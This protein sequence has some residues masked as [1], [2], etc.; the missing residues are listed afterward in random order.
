MV[1]FIAATLFVLLPPTVLCLNAEDC[2]TQDTT[3]TAEDLVDSLLDVGSSLA[4]QKLCQEAGDQQ[5][6]H[7]TWYN[8]EASPISLMC[9]LFSSPTTSSPCSHCVSGPASCAT[10]QGCVPPPPQDHGEWYCLG[11]DDRLTC[12]LECHPGYVSSNRTMVRCS[13]DQWSP[14]PTST[15]VAPIALITGGGLPGDTP[16]RVRTVELYGDGVHKY[17]PDLPQHREIHSITYID[18]FVIICGGSESESLYMY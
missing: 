8:H 16:G 5:C 13:E 2:F 15:C 9:F 6:S 12:H 18:S 4:C 10:P 14:G 17:L 7:F 3:W 1:P 11:S